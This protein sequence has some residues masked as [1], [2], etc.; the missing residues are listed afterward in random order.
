MAV[1][2]HPTAIVDPA[3]EIGDGTVVGP[4]MV[5]EAGAV[6]GRDNELCAFSHVFGSVRMGD[7]NRLMRA[8]S[9]GGVP[10]DLKYKGEPTRC[11][12]G[13]G[14]FIGENAIV[15]RGT[16]ATGE[17]VL[18][19]GNF[20]M[21]NIHVGHDC[22]LGSSI[23]MSSGAILGGN[24]RVGD[25]ANFGG[26]AGVHQ[27]CRVGEMAMVG[28]L[29]R[30]RQDVLPFTM[31]AEANTL[32]GLN[33]VGLRRAGHSAQDVQPLRE[34]YRRFCEAREP[35]AEFR[36]WLDAQPENPLLAVW[37]AFLSQPSKRG[38]ARGSGASAENSRDE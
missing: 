33:R 12:V 8:A 10:Q 35:L 13:N 27:F 11:V 38:Y 26:N 34:A 30:V 9:L 2:I 23:V 32:Y 29:A 3:A 25:R 14:N 21:S 19:D 20:L 37:R 28:G 22:R 6:I 7:G 4:F 36:A 16:T 15:H 5:V 17:T 1:T 24:S 18:G 31:I